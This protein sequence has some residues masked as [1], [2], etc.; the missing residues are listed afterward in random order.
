MGA[1]YGNL[2]HQV[3]VTEPKS[4]DSP[5]FSGLPSEFGWWRVRSSRYPV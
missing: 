2:C 3:P 4:T 1:D 5:E